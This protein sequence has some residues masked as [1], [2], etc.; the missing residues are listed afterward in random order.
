MFFS[1]RNYSKSHNT[2][3]I[4]STHSFAHITWS[5]MVNGVICYTW[6]SAPSSQFWGRFWFLWDAHFKL[7]S[8]YNI[9]KQ[10]FILILSQNVDNCLIVDLNHIY[11]LHLFPENPRFHVS[12]NLEIIHIWVVNPSLSEPGPHRPILSIVP[13]LP[14]A[15]SKAI[16]ITVSILYFL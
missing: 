16:L 3:F 2:A 13:L 10:F 12:T 15:G 8:H 4:T 11:M 9:T 6:K 1:S 7:W 14:L 5:F